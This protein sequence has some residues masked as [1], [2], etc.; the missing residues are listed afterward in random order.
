M[1]PRSLT[2]TCTNPR[3]ERVRL[4]RTYHPASSRK[5]QLS[6][7][8]WC[9]VVSGGLIRQ[10]EPPFLSLY[11]TV[12]YRTVIELFSKSFRFQ[13]QNSVQNFSCEGQSKVRLGDEV[14]KS[15]VAIFTLIY[16]LILFSC[17]W[18]DMC[19]SVIA[20]HTTPQHTT[21]HHTGKQI[22]KT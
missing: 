2:D 5:Q 22:E 8:W 7:P 20:Y 1:S 14:N 18:K 15:Q 19:L 10:R 9:S 17:G 12:S 3:K 11:V 21:P 13:C 16:F 4:S 6:L